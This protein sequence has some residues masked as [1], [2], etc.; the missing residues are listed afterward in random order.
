MEKNKNFITII[1]ILTILTV[2]IATGIKVY[3]A[4]IDNI[5]KVTTKKICE[6]TRNCYL[7]NK[8]EGNSI[9]IDTLI[10]NNYLEKLVDPKT[11]EYIDG[12]IL[13]RYESGICSVDIK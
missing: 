2:A 5:Y 13:V 4:H 10:S 11:K 12:N 3:T 7:D 9:K 1:I 8:C 6:A